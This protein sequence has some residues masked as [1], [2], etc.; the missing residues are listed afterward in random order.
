MSL[1]RLLFF[2]ASVAVVV[3]AASCREPSQ[4]VIEARTNV[5]HQPGYVTTFTVGPHA[6]LE[7]APPTTETRE[8]WGA[9]GFIGSL[10]AVPGSG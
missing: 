9:D 8:P 7:D 10:V 2:S 4:V 1:K 6:S 5:V 3:A